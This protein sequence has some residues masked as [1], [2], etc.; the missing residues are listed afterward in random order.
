M[1]ITISIP[2]DIYEK[3]ERDRGMIPRSTY[4]QALI[5]GEVEDWEKV[6]KQEQEEGDE[7]KTY[8]KK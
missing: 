4:I 7:F 1:K 2:K 5:K 6:D 8:F 3:L